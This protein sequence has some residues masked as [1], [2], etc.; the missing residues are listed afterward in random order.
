VVEHHREHGD[1]LADR[2]LAKAGSMELGDELRHCLGVDP[3]DGLIAETRF[4]CSSASA[5]I[6]PR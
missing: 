4:C 1:G 2:L 3:L 5:P 6:H